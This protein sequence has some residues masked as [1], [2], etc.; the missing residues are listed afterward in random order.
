MFCPL[1][2]TFATLRELGTII[3]STAALIK[4]ALAAFLARE[5]RELALCS[6]FSNISYGSRICNCFTRNGGGETVCYASLALELDLSVFGACQASTLS[7]VCSSCGMMLSQPHKIT[8]ATLRMKFQDY[9]NL[10]LI[11]SDTINETGLIELGLL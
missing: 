4:V 5:L 3:A 1:R 11:R 6:F 10:N 2:G 7:K 9:C 8:R